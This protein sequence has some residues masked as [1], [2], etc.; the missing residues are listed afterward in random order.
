[1]KNIKFLLILFGILLTIQSCE[2]QDSIRFPELLDAANVRIQIDPDYS[3]LDASDIQNAKIV[4]STFSENTNIESVVISASYYNFMNDTSYDSR[5]IVRYSQSDYDASNGAIRDEEFTSE[6]LAQAFGLTGGASDLGGGDR[7]DFTNLTT[8]TNGMVFPDTILSET[9]HE[10]VNVTPN[11]INSSATTSF[12]VGFNAF[13]ACPVP[14]GFALGDYLLEQTS[15]PA[16]PFFGNP[17]RWAPEIV[18]L[19]QVSAIERSFNGTYFTFE[20]ITFNFLLIC[21]NILVGTTGSGLSCGGPGINWVGDT[22]PGS[23]DEEDD[24]II[25]IKVLDNV[26][27]G[28]GLP[29]AEPMTLR[30]TKIN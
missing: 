5:E 9:D 24:N 8:L 23:Y 1:M 19:T 7:F 15:G 16:D 2:D 17:T 29:A 3:S 4:Y 30:L 6:L 20:N 21:E 22:P 27:G 26:D 12:T 14:E 10:T 18:T 11:I 25:I 13:V 28:C